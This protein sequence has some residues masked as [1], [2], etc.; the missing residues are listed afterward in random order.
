MIS[1]G[2]PELLGVCDRIYVM[3]EGR[4]VAEMPAA[5]ASQEKIMRAI[6]RGREV[7]V[8]EMAGKEVAI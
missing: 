4:F 3:N 2:M 5:E 8:R 1:S 7:P 6:M